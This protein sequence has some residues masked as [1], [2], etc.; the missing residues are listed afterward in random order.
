MRRMF[1]ALRNFI[2]PVPEPLRGTFRGLATQEVTQY[3]RKLGVTSV[4]LLPIHMFADDS[5]LVDK[6]LVNYWGYSSLAFFTPSRRYASVPDFAFSEFKE[7][8][9]RP[10]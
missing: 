8:V 7:M 10:T 5:Y 1:A 6:G 4:E 9:S 3:I 2:L